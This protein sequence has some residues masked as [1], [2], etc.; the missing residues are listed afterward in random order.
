MRS[1]DSM[2]LPLHTWIGGA[3]RQRV[4]PAVALRLEAVSSV[5]EAV[6]RVVL[7]S[8]EP[9]V[10]SLIA[11]L[12]AV[13]NT[14]APNIELALQFDAQLDASMLEPL[15]EAGRRL[16]LAYIAD[17]CA[18]LAKPATLSPAARHRLRFPR[19][20]VRRPIRRAR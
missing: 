8:A 14:L 20:A 3:S 6:R 12:V 2:M 17:P 10:A 4:T 18:D 5:P 7:A 16:K 15:R 1:A 9:D 13:A 11:S 19:T